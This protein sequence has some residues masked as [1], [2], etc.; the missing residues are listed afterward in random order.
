LTGITSIAFLLRSKVHIKGFSFKKTEKAFEQ[1]SILSCSRIYGDT[2]T[3]EEDRITGI[4]NNV[5]IV[6]DDMDFGSKGIKKLV[7]CGRSAID[8]NTV[9]IRFNGAD[10]ELIQLAEFQYEKR[11][12][13]HEFVLENITGLQS[14]AFIFLPGS[15]FD[16]KW[17]RFVTA[18]Q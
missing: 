9:H 2:Y 5:T 12:K 6:F 10:G 3:I 11:C 1:L 17:F 8:K 18:D 16:F 14:V 4:G 13:E 15:N 7:I